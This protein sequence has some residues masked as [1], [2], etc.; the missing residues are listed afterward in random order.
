M[1]ISG[2]NRFEL[3]FA[4]TIDRATGDGRRATGDLPVESI[5]WED[6][7]STGT[8]QGWPCR[9]VAARFTARSWS[10]TGVP[11][12]GGSRRCCAD[13]WTAL[14]PSASCPLAAP[15]SR[16]PCVA[17]APAPVPPSSGRSASARVSLSPS[18]FP[19]LSRRIH[20][21]GSILLEITDPSA[22]GLV[23]CWF[24]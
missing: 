19:P 3:L 20:S 7:E 24:R 9:R 5:P 18:A 17:S 11:V 12:T 15:R 1:L 2:P 16:R 6:E 4:Q 13:T 14:W 10:A 22:R 8:E 21:R 23:S